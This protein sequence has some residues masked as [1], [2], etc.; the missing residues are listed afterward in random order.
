MSSF[1]KDLYYGKII[2]EDNF[3]PKFEEYK[4]MRQQHNEH[5]TDFV[6][7]LKALDSSLP[8]QLLTILD[9]QAEAIPIET[10][11]MFIYGFRM[12]AKMM[13]EVLIDPTEST[14]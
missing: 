1:L 4:E 2:P 5:F 10:A 8:T 6:E 7:K 14:K 11:E 12:G 3:S 9:E 13:L